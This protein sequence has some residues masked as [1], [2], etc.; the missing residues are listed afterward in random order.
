VTARALGLD[1]ND[2][3]ARFVAGRVRKGAFEIV[4]AGEVPSAELPAA[5]KAAGLKGWPA[6]VGVTGRD[7]I[8]RTTQVPPVPEWQLRELMKLEIAEVAEHAGDELSADHGLL[9]GAARHGDQDFALLALVRASVLEE[10]AAEV[11]RDGIKLRAFAPKAV[12]LHDAVCAVDGAEGTVLTA[13]LDEGTTDLAL[14]EDGELLFARNLAGGLDLFEKAVGEAMALDGARV[15]E[16]CRKLA[17]FPGPGEK[18][19]G[20]QGTVA[21]ALETP[22]R[23]LVGMLQSTVLLCKNQLKATDLRLTRVLLC[24]PGASLP[25][26]DAALTRA[27]GVPV[28]VFDPTEGYLVGSA[29]VPAGRGPAFAAAAGLA[30]MA[31]L[32]DAYRLEILTDKQRGAQR[33]RTRTIWV[34]LAALLVLGHLVHAFLGAR[35]NFELAERDVTALRREVEA[36]KADQRTAERTAQEARELSGRLAAF[37]DLTAPGSGLLA[38]LDLLDADLPPDLWASSVRSNRAVEPEFAHG[39]ER[40]PFIVVDGSGKEQSRSLTDAVA[41]LTNKLRTD[42]HVAAVKPRFSTDTRNAFTWSLSVDTSVVPG[43]AKAAQPA[44]AAADPE[45]T[46]APAPAAKRGAH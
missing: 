44:E 40:R 1:V 11:A 12:A 4:Q 13:C 15:R 8:L 9:P 25:G 32:P 37:E 35:S 31:T 16:A 5:L 27:L 2:D 38:V 28:A 45:P 20:T 22:L 10:R 43:G 33:F 3:T 34:L 26:L 23:Q 29:D 24:G 17:I 14:T 18:L 36:R 30:L 42:P 39:T 7:M 6:M 19:A 46:P 41:E 21:R